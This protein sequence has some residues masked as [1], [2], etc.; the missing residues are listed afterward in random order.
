MIGKQ[1]CG[2]RVVKERTSRTEREVIIMC[3]THEAEWQVRHDA[4]RATRWSGDRELVSNKLT[5]ENDD[6]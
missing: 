4:A 6:G 2:C 1:P 3:A 5:E